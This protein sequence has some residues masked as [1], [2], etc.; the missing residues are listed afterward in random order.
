VTRTYVF[1]DIDGTLISTDGAG[2]RAW[3]RAATEVLGQ[4]DA[5]ADLE[6]AGSSDAEIAMAVCRAADVDEAE[7]A[8]RLLEAVQRALPRELRVGIGRVLANV[9]ENLEAL[10]ARDDVV[11][12]L[13]TGNVAANGR[14]KL[15]R[16]DLWRFFGAG[17]AF[18]VAGTDRAGIA[19]RART[20]AI[21]HAGQEVA[22]EQ[23]V[24]IGDTPHD[25]ACGKAI[26]ART[27]AVATGHAYT[28]GELEAQ[29]PWRALP[30]LPEPASLCATLGLALTEG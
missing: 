29:Q 15:E 17:G 3:E 11:N 13:L 2:R 18:S 30:V 21:E 7:C 16:F 6:T 20:L 22:G 10:S 24:V 12:M 27:I 23:M 26:G 14:F 28:L 25:I 5:F 9:R 1:W 19:R 4:R 8:P